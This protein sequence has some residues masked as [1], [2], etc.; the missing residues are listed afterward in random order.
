MSV[1]SSATLAPNVKALAMW[2]YSVLR[3][4]GAAAD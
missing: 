2:R 4:L 1:V 3:L